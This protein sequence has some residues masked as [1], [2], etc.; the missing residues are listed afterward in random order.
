MKEMQCLRA[1]S[2][3]VGIPTLSRSG[4]LLIHWEYLNVVRGTYSDTGACVWWHC[5]GLLIP[6]GSEEV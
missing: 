5:S 1:M 6:I 2:W 3:F 4:Y